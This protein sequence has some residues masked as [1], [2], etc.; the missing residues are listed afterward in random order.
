M[1]KDA[2]WSVFLSDERRYADFINGFALN[3]QQLVTED[4]IQELD[5]GEKPW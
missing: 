5:T 1:G 4:D 2:E 3:G